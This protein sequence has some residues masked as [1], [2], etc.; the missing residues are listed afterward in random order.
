MADFALKAGDSLRSQDQAGRVGP[1]RRH[2]RVP[3]LGRPDP[4]Q[5][6]PGRQAGRGRPAAGRQGVRVHRQAALL[7]AGRRPDLAAAAPRHL[8]DR[9]PGAAD[10]RPEERRTRAPSISVKLV[11]RSGRGHDRRRRRQV[12]GR[13]RRDR[14]PRRRHRRLAV[15]VDQ[16]CRHAVGDRPGRDAADAGAE[17][18][19]RPHPRAGRRPDED[20]PRRR[21][22]RAAGRRRVRL[23][24]R[25]AGGRGLHHDAQV[26]PQHLPGGRGHAGP[27][28]AQEVRR[29]SPSTSSTTSSSSPRKRARSWRSWA[30]ASST[31]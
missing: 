11:S 4:D 17:P 28:A 2:G 12:Q 16:A 7:G 8:L 23:R 10:P 20:R 3:G 1:L 5:D 15:V 25:A 21:H 26:P 22:R 9:G 30:S 31:T 13:P 18:P 27:G 14:R 24:H 19:A 29:A 6:G